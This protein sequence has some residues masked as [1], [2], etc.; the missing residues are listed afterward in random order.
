MNIAFGLSMEMPWAA[1]R[2]EK[3]GKLM[4]AAFLRMHRQFASVI[5]IHRQIHV[6]MS[7]MTCTVHRCSQKFPH[8]FGFQ[9][10]AH[11]QQ[12]TL[13]DHM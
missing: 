10:H 2:K 11:Q 6:A 13:Y 8:A 4:K 3:D 12:I 1:W 5:V 9:P 7:A